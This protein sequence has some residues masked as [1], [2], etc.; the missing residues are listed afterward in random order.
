MTTEEKIKNKILELQLKVNNAKS[1]C[2][3]NKEITFGGF[4]AAVD[5]VKYREQIKLLK[6]LLK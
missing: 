1:E 3:R 5:L 6:S 4:F 2:K